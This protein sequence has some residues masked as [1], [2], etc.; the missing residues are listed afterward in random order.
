MI[1]AKLIRDVTSNWKLIDFLMI[2]RD[3]I[4]FAIDLY[5]DILSRGLHSF[6]LK[7]MLLLLL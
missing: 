7:Y 6:T 5:M 1:E 2:R 4:G 3:F